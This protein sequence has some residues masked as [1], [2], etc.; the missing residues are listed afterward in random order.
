MMHLQNIGK[1]I[2]VEDL[3]DYICQ[4][5]VQAHYGMKKGI[6]LQIAQNWLKRLGFWWTKKPKEQYSDG[7]EWGDVA[8][9]EF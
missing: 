2:S 9:V 8:I 1:Y 5:E 6:T 3:R 7:H 4:P